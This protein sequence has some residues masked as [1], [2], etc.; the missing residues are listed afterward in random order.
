MAS[1]RDIP[2]TRDLNQRRGLALAYPLSYTTNAIYGN[3]YQDWSHTTLQRV[4]PYVKNRQLDIL[5][6][7]VKTTSEEVGYYYRD[8]QSPIYP[9]YGRKYTNEAPTGYETPRIVD[10]DAGRN[11]YLPTVERTQDRRTQTIEMSE[12][13][14]RSPRKLNLPNIESIDITFADDSHAKVHV[15]DIDFY[16]L[17]QNGE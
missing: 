13:P 9:D 5:H 1:P 12:P 10:K 7:R 14:A 11:W 16:G 4:E 6:S 8:Y 15:K 17:R 2:G 3:F